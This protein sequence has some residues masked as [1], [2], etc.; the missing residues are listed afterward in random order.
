MRASDSKNQAKP[1]ANAPYVTLPQ[2]YFIKNYPS[3]SSDSFVNRV[4]GTTNWPYLN[5]LRLRA[6]EGES[7]ALRNSGASSPTCLRQERSPKPL[8]KTLTRRRSKWERPA[9]RNQKCKLS[10]SFSVI[11]APSIIVPWNEGS[12][13]SPCIC[14][15]QSS[16]SVQAGL[17]RRV[18]SKTSPRNR[19]RP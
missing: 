10:K 6:P 16:H 18:S 9:F 5:S 7:L 3:R 15:D 11:R 4:S 14:Y 13:Y 8:P 1:T 12:I 17:I 2:L 19:D